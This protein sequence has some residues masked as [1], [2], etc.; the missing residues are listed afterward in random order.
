MKPNANAAQITADTHLNANCSPSI[1]VKAGTAL[2]DSVVVIELFSIS[3]VSSSDRTVFV[4][5]SGKINA[6]GVKE[7]GNGRVID[8]ENHAD[9]DFQLIDNR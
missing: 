8:Q 9:L 4:T 7:L 2:D 5:L 1:G 3:T 6:I